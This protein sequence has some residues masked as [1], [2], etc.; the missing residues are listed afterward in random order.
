MKNKELLEKLEDMDSK[1]NLL[2][3]KAFNAEKDKEQV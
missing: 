2:R 1:M 3:E